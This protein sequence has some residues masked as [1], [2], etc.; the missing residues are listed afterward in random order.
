[1]SNLTLKNMSSKID[2]IFEI[3]L[4]DILKVLYYV[5]DSPY[6]SKNL[7]RLSSNTFHCSDENVYWDFCELL[8]DNKFEYFI[9]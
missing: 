2:A 8:E 9:S 4:M 5:N 1:M 6:F 3:S 7:K